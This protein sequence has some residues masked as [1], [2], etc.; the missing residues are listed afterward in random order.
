MADINRPSFT[1]LDQTTA[2]E[3][4]N[5]LQTGI[6]Q[7]MDDIISGDLANASSSLANIQDQFNALVDGIKNNN[8]YEQL[9]DKIQQTNLM[10]EEFRIK[11]E[12]GIEAQ[13]KSIKN[14][15]DSLPKVLNLMRD[16]ESSIE[17]I[18]K[19]FGSTAELEKFGS[20]IISMKQSFD[21]IVSMPLLDEGTAI[22]SA[23]KVSQLY[24]EAMKSAFQ[25]ADLGKDLIVNSIGDNKEEIANEV[26]KIL[27]NTQIAMN[28][29]PNVNNFQSS[30]NSGADLSALNKIMNE[31]VS[32]S[33]SSLVNSEKTEK[34]LDKINSFI[35]SIDNNKVNEMSTVDK[36]TETLDVLTGI[37]SDLKDE[38]T[39]KA[40]DNVPELN[41]QIGRA[42]CRERV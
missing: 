11:T 24:T 12:Q 20:E 42:S 33:S 22:N 31:I 16:M 14:M 30:G 32:I 17:N 41:A 27:S 40:G 38:K 19:Q 35:E 10:I 21:E 39:P 3:N 29:V 34:T 8:I 36:T 4:I 9:Q 7:G 18:N 6:K 26:K 13:E 37:R 15:T 23:K 28:I 2:I 25:M 5:N 1:N